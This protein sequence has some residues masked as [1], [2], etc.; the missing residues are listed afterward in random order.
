MRKII[1]N[2]LILSLIVNIIVII[3]N[4]VGIRFFDYAPFTLRVPGGDCIEYIGPLVNVTIVYELGLT[5]VIP[6]S[7]IE[8]HWVT[9]LVSFVIFFSIF[10]SIGLLISL[11]R[12]H[13]K[14]AGIDNE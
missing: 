12:K 5:N 3:I 8:Y 9:L 11:V 1:R 2:S 14:K 4:L 6:T 7:I 10:F 13:F